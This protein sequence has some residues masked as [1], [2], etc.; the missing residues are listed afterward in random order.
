M[1]VATAE[2]PGGGAAAAGAGHRV[3]GHGEMDW[4][5]TLLGRTRGA[6]GDGLPPER[7]NHYF[8]PRLFGEIATA[9]MVDDL[10]SIGREF[11]PDLVLAEAYAFAGPLAAA[12]LG[13][14]LV[15][16]LIGPLMSH[17]VMELVND[18][19]TPMWRS[20]G[21]DSP[22][23]GGV[24]A[25]TTIE[26]SP[27]SLEPLSL[28]EGEGLRL[29]PAPLPLRSPA[30]TDPPTVY[31][32]LGTFFGG[33]THVFRAAL[34]ALADEPVRVVT[35][36]GAGGDPAALDPVPPNARVERY[37]PQAE[38]LPDCSVVIHHGGAGTMFGSL[39]HGIP[40]V[41]IPQ[42]ADN[43]INGSLVQRCGI[44]T[45]IGPDEAS[46]ERIRTDVLR[47]MAD[48]QAHQ[49]GR[50]LAAEIAEMPSAADV[51]AQLRARF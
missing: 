43:F 17:D 34:E 40:Q 6:P 37:I 8:L 32:T 18:A 12:V 5:Q 20:F 47:L 51:A 41:V 26:V 30:P 1:V 27:P 39:A 38:L 50:Q 31:L 35:T 49:A 9:D 48:P 42:G 4:F 23:F 14:P 16:H 19:V 46:A 29:R 36:V 28:P 3:V 24:Y 13:V 11:Q 2:D 7:I 25:G 45:S 44:G 21:L 33:N 10:I 15:H 22:R